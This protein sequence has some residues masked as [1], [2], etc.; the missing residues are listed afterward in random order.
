MSTSF[1]IHHMLN[2]TVAFTRKP[3]TTLIL[4]LFVFARTWHVTL[5]PRLSILSCLPCSTKTLATSFTFSSSSGFVSDI[6]TTASS[7]PPENRCACLYRLKCPAASST[8]Y[9]APPLRPN[10][11]A[12]KK[13]EP[14]ICCC[15]SHLKQFTIGKTL[16]RSRLESAMHSHTISEEPFRKFVSDF[17]VRDE[18]LAAGYAWLED[19]L[20]SEFFF[21]YLSCCRQVGLHHLQLFKHLFGGDR[22]T[23]FPFHGDTCCAALLYLR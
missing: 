8:H 11:C 9:V 18:P 14:I 21:Q 1:C 13:A 2:S 16:F 19:N 7:H 15:G 20:C 6:L 23:D 12:F 4:T 3:L 17:P 22:P 5:V 10:A